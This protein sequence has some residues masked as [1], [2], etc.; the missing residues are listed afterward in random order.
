MRFIAIW[1]VK[2]CPYPGQLRALFGLALMLTALAASNAF[3][4][5]KSIEDV[6]RALKAGA[7]SVEALVSRLHPEILQ[8]PVLPYD[9]ITGRASPERP[10]I[11]G[12]MDDAS[13]FMAVVSDEKL[14]TANQMEF[15]QV[16]PNTGEPDFYLIDF[17][18]PNPQ[19]QKNPEFCMRCHQQGTRRVLRAEGYPVW[20]GWFG[21]VVH[22]GIS[23][24]HPELVVSEN[25]AIQR[26]FKARSEIPLLKYFDVSELRPVFSLDGHLAGERLTD[27]AIHASAKMLYHT[28]KTY[29]GFEQFK[30]ALAS[31]LYLASD[32]RSLSLLLPPSQLADFHR[33]EPAIVSDIRAAA[34]ET[35]NYLSAFA[36]KT[37]GVDIHMQAV[38][39]DYAWG[40]PLS[41]LE[42]FLRKNGDSLTNYST[43]GNR[44]TMYIHNGRSDNGI[45]GALLKRMIEDI[46]KTSGIEIG[47]EF[48]AH[49]P[50]RPKQKIARTPRNIQRLE[51]LEDFLFRARKASASSGPFCELQTVN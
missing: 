28:L 17:S 35:G 30:F 41:L 9:S 10:R 38:H 20:L 50:G 29:P 5:I 22:P 15:A 24:H 11:V 48:E 32:T 36:K 33:A 49:A 4:Y 34:E 19:L 37:N 40:S 2:L 23:D 26:F 14:Q 46:E 31:H 7:G 13:F 27:L 3:A 8:R 42:W 25:L 12:A 51:G 21:T 1:R 18:Q 43:S 6:D 47:L 39:A 45:L 44:S 16:D